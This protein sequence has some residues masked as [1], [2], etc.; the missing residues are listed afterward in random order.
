[1]RGT[2][3]SWFRL[4]ATSR[5]RRCGRRCRRDALPRRRR[6]NATGTTSTAR[7]RPICSSMA[8]STRGWGARRSWV[9]RSITWGMTRVRAFRHAAVPRASPGALRSRGSRGW[10]PTEPC[11]RPTMTSTTDHRYPTTGA[12]EAQWQI[13]RSGLATA[14]SDK[15]GGEEAEVYTF[16]PRPDFGAIDGGH[17]HDHCLRRPAD[18]R[19]RRAPARAAQTPTA[20]IEAPQ[21]FLLAPA[22]RMTTP[23]DPFCRSAGP[24][25]RRQRRDLPAPAID[26]LRL[27]RESGLALCRRRV[28]RCAA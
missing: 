11:G 9:W 16:R 7:A 17:H 27:R 22:L 28:H 21:R 26:R 12:L 1:M 3:K 19:L 25:L 8:P 14:A 24:I 18:A 6:L 23:V 20:G 2:A 4:L 15:L 13:C 5:R 10:V